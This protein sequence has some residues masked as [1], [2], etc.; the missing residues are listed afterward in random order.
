MNN[1]QIEN[2]QI[3]NASSY[4]K[5]QLTTP[6][7]ERVGIETPFGLVKAVMPSDINIGR[8]SFT[9]LK[10]AQNIE[11]VIASLIY[12]CDDEDEIE[13]DPVDDEL[14]AD[15]LD[16]GAM[17]GLNEDCGIDDTEENDNLAGI[18]AG[19]DGADLGDNLDDEAPDED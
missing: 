18:G 13:P 6:N 8:V 11:G 7:L 15:G 2:N 14:G 10:T 16:E 5:L 12:R 3:N 17:I 4:I 19:G 9:T 1:L